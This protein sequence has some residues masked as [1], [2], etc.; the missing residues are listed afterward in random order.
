MESNDMVLNGGDRLTPKVWTKRRQQTN[1]I[2]VSAAL[3]FGVNLDRTNPIISNTHHATNQVQPKPHKG[4]G[5]FQHGKN[6]PAKTNIIIHSSSNQ[7]ELL[8]NNKD[9]NNSILS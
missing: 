1:L 6:E 2:N 9:L 8:V 4:Q 5:N 7:Y 3:T